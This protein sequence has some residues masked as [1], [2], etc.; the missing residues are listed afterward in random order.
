[1]MC[2]VGLA[3]SEMPDM[4]LINYIEQTTSPIGVFLT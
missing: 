1:M 2:D 4:N 3:I